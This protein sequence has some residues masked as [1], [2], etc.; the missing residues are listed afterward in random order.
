[1]WTTWP[2]IG[3]ALKVSE[4]WGFEHVTGLP[5]VKITKNDRLDYG[6]GYWM[7]GASEPILLSKKP[8]GPS[9]RRP[10]L[11]LLTED[12]P[13][14]LVAENLGHSRKPDSL[15]E[16]V[17]GRKAT[18]EQKATEPYPGPW[19]ELFARRPRPNWVTVGNEIHNKADIRD[20]L[21]GL[22]LL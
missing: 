21:P 16:I 2:F 1:M 12:D 15:H 3:D 22:I 20:T 6:V 18:D 4:A 5:W 10:W 7:R 19:L 13:A 11:G 8:G 14:T 17:E 9:H